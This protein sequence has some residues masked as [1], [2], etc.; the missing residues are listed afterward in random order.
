MPQ[1]ACCTWAVQWRTW[2]ETPPHPSGSVAWPGPWWSPPSP[3]CH[4]SANTCVPA[5][6]HA[7]TQPVR[8]RAE[9]ICYW[10]QSMDEGSVRVRETERQTDRQTEREWWGDRRKGE[11]GR[12]HRKWERKG[13]RDKRCRE[14]NGDGWDGGWEETRLPQ[15]TPTQYRYQVQLWERTLN[16]LRVRGSLIKKEM[17]SNIMQEVNAERKSDQTELGYTLNYSGENDRKARNWAVTFH[18]THS[19]QWIFH[20]LH[21]LFQLGTFRQ[22]GLR[23]NLHSASK[24]TS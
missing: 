23:G 15:E 2:S 8:C 24:Q 5:T 16:I 10:F 17:L 7:Q 6:L 13:E 18:W 1:T 21:P 19:V 3:C 11:R 14:R 22:R 20:I 12:R 9:N 4:P